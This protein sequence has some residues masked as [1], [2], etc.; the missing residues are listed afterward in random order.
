MFVQMVEWLKVTHSKVEQ[1]LDNFLLYVQE[2]SEELNRSSRPRR[3]TFPGCE[4]SPCSTFRVQP[5]RHEPHSSA[6]A[7][8][9]GV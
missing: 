7:E 2:V 3:Q 6:H 9:L 1:R 5:G 8:P 4:G